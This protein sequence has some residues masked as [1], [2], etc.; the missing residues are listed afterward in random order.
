M[1]VK[2]DFEDILLSLVNSFKKTKSI[3]IG[4]ISKKINEKEKALSVNKTKLS[5]AEI[6]LIN[7]SKDL[8]EA[9]EELQQL[10]DS[11]Q[12]AE[13]DLQNKLS[14]LVSEDLLNSPIETYQDLLEGVKVLYASLD[15]TKQIGLEPYKLAEQ[16][17]RLSGKSDNE[18][19]DYEKLYEEYLSGNNNAANVEKFTNYIAK[20]RNI[21][22]PVEVPKVETPKIEAPKTNE[23]SGKGSTAQKNRT[24]SI[25]VTI[26]NLDELLTTIDSLFKDKKIS[27]NND[28]YDAFKKKIQSSF[29]NIDISSIAD[30]INTS[31]ASANDSGKAAKNASSV[32]GSTASESRALTEKELR[33]MVKDH[34]DKKGLT[35]NERKSYIDAAVKELKGKVWTS[36][37]E[38]AGNDSTEKASDNS[39]NLTNIKKSIQESLNKQAFKIKV[40]LN[41][42]ESTINADLEEFLTDKNVSVTVNQDSVTAIS[43]FI[44]SMFADV[45]LGISSTSISDINTAIEN[46][47]T[48]KTLSATLN[49]DSVTAIDNYVNTMFADMPL[50]ISSDSIENIRT[51]IE[52]ALK[53]INITIKAQAVRQQKGIVTSDTTVEDFN[54][55][56]L[57]TKRDQ[58]VARMGKLKNNGLRSSDEYKKLNA[59]LKTID[60]FLDDIQNATKTAPDT[61]VDDLIKTRLTADKRS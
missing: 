15:V 18:N 39:I 37:S 8:T 30:K 61:K 29:D 32:K 4:D 55:S 56:Q 19:V 20:Q 57:Y 45:P 25:N 3:N 33:A 21:K 60:K 31:V 10:T 59:V 2:E 58:I 52:N 1:S 7:A 28:S 22:E 17:K 48:N 6:E 27:I 41:K 34:A 12:Q 14:E 11:L 40:G 23:T 44:D 16:L 13:S 49:Q 43:N 46:G 35:G 51:E 47:V 50:T 53:K 26:A 9:N 5:F 38:S 54:Q 42:D 36:Q 24:A